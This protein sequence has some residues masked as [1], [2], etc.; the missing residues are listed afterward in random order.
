MLGVVEAP[1]Q[2]EMLILQCV[3]PA[4]QHILAVKKGGAYTYDTLKASLIARFGGQQHTWE[5]KLMTLRQQLGQP[6]ASYAGVFRTNLI[7]TGLTS[8]NH[9]VVNLFMN[10]LV[11]TPC[12]FHVRS[13]NPDTIEKAVQL[14]EVWEDAFRVSLPYA[15]Q[16]GWLDGVVPFASPAAFTPPQLYPMVPTNNP[17]Q[18]LQTY[19]GGTY[20]PPPPTSS[21]QQRSTPS[22]PAVAPVYNINTDRAATESVLKDVLA[23]FENRI[24]QY[25]QTV[26]NEVA[27]PVHSNNQPTSN[28]QQASHQSNQ[29]QAQGA[30]NNQQ[31]GQQNNQQQ[32]GGG[33]GSGKNKRNNGGGG[34]NQ[35]WNGWQQLCVKVV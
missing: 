20:F 27:R 29:Q 22:I 15:A 34:N 35:P 26:V 3:G 7:R 10:G 24:T 13:G 17:P 32:G 25:V 4:A 2:A 12:R 28:Q 31:G 33:N 14:A 8:D 21:M 16:F 11:Y 9:L 23:S 18:Q 6:V 30:P 5:T 19:P 1:K